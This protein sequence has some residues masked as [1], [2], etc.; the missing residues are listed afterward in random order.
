MTDEQ[1]FE[2]CVAESVR[3][4]GPVSASDG[5]HELTLSRVRRSR[6]DPR[7]LALIKEPPMRSNSQP[8]VG[9]PTVRVMAI[10]AATVVLALTLAAAGAGAQRLFASNGP[11]V[12]AADGSGDFATIGDAVAVAD[13]GDT[14]KVRPGTYVEAVVI[15]SDVALEGEGEREAIVIQAPDDGPSWDTRF[16]WIGEKPFA[17]VLAGSSGSVSDLSLIGE[18]SRLFVDGG[19]ATVTRVMFDEVGTPP[20]G[21]GTAVTRA[22]VVTGGADADVHD[23]DFVG[24]NGVNVF[25]LSLIHISEPTRRATISRMPSSA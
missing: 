14:I 3:S 7:W 21:A 5:A 13:D 19:D 6:Q 16:P 25:D 9:S 8:V 12:V 17:I 2:R 1:T 4:I 20:A 22:L 23:N 24:G 10:L 11:L 15:E 18:D